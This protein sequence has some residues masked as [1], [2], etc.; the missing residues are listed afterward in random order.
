LAGSF[1]VAAAIPSTRP[2]TPGP[3]CQ[4]L[5]ECD[6]FLQAVDVVLP[7]KLQFAFEIRVALFEP[8]HVLLPEF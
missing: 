1:T 5:P 8:M 2:V 7:L 3:F 4:L 6:E